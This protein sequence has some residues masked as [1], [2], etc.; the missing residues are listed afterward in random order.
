M[1]LIIHLHI[2]DKSVFVPPRGGEQ[3]G[4]LWLLLQPRWPLG[5]SLVLC[6]SAVRVN[7]KNEGLTQR[8]W[9]PMGGFC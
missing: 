7:R 4:W 3:P 8:Q 9:K 6:C 5:V 1:T 2:M